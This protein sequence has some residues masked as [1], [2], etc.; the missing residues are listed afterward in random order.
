MTRGFSLEERLRHYSDVDPI[1]GCWIWKAATSRFGYGQLRYKN[2]WGLAHRFSYRAF[3]GNI[4]A[5]LF[6]LHSCHTPSCIN[7]EHLRTGTHKDNASDRDRAGRNGSTKLASEAVVEI[8]RL[9]DLGGTT[10][11]QLGEQFGVSR[12]MIGYIVGRSAWKHI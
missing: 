4:P 2:E 8:R 7:P 3:I 10:Q 5:G 1:T 9:Y 11:K 6:V 12:A